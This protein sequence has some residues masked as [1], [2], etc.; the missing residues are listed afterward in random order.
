VNPGID[1]QDVRGIHAI[2]LGFIPA[3]DQ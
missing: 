3:V 2:R 1:Q